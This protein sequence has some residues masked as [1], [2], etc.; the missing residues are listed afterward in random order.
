MSEHDAT[1]EVNNAMAQTVAQQ[2]LDSL[3]IEPGEVGYMTIS[4]T[5]ENGGQTFVQ[6]E[7]AGEHAGEHARAMIGAVDFESHPATHIRVALGRDDDSD[8]VSG[9][10]GAQQRLGDGETEES[11]G[12][13][14]ALQN[15]R[16]AMSVKGRGEG[17]TREMDDIATTQPNVAEPGDVNPNTRHHELLYILDRW[18]RTHGD[19]EWAT[20]REMYDKADHEFPTKEAFGSSLSTLFLEK[21]LVDRT[22]EAQEQGGVR[23]R[24]RLNEAGREQLHEL[25]TPLVFTDDD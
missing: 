15:R 9:V 24:Y 2:V 13:L 8:D 22:K 4:L 5:T 12:D 23:N 6:F 20:V 7:T 19:G 25:G 16:E 14:A 18:E 17:A 3:G 21:A 10:S 1:I 11:N